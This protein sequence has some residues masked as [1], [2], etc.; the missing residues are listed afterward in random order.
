MFYVDYGTIA[1]VEIFRLRRLD[2][3]FFFL[4]AQALQCQLSDIV[5]PPTT[6][7]WSGTATC[8]CR[9]IIYRL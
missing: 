7:R 2:P 4:P 1:V 3:Q 5:P 6:A 9:I 8:R